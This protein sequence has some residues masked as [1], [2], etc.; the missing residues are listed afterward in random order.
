MNKDRITIGLKRCSWLF[1]VIVGIVT[2]VIVA[3][4]KGW[5]DPNDYMPNTFVASLL[6]LIVFRMGIW[7]FQGFMGSGKKKEEK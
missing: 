4:N 5:N 6:G 3:S 1:A 2:I 7:V